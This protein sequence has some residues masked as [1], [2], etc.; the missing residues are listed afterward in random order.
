MPS[1]SWSVEEGSLAWAALA[2]LKDHL[3]KCPE[4]AEVVVWNGHMEGNWRSLC[5]NYL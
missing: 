3:G 4:L 5:P 2:A 1:R